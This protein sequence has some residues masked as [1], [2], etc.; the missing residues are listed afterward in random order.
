VPVNKYNVAESVK[1]YDKAEHVV[2]KGPLSKRD[3]TTLHKY[4]DQQ[5]LTLQRVEADSFDFIAD[6]TDLRSLTLYGCKIGDWSPLAKLKRLDHL[7]INTV[8]DKTPDF[9]FLSRLEKLTDLGIGYVPHLTALPDM[10]RC[11]RLRRLSLFNLQRLKD[12]SAVLKIKNLQSFHIVV[13]PQGPSD[14]IDIMAMPK[15]KF[16][17]GSFGTRK[18]NE[19]FREL[20]AKHKL[21]YGGRNKAK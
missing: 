5:T 7:F 2:A 1:R 18:K 17:T 6:W 10:S 3:L 21:V 15:M 4:R 14:L 11:K 13:T 19:L 9:S 12:L 8:R 16:M 20:M